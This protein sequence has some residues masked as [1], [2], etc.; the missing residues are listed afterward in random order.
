MAGAG[1]R[2]PARYGRGWRFPVS[3]DEQPEPEGQDELYAAFEALGG[4]LT[5]DE[6][7]RLLGSDQY[8]PALV[9]QARLLLD[10]DGAAAE[11]VVQA[12]FA[13]LQDAWSR[14]GDPGQQARVWLLRAT[15]N[16]SRSV[17]RHRDAGGR[18]A[19]QPAADAPGAADQA[20]GGPDLDAG[21]GALGAL[22]VRQRE[23]VVLHTRQGLSRR[24]AA[25]VM[26]ISVGAFSSHLARGTSSRRHPPQPK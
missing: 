23:A 16:R 4:P 3:H 11:Q 17:R 22:P 18:G 9:Q 15:V 12:S 1:G 25:Q 26:G 13:A 14:L 20:A 10:G 8:R 24:Q 7:T 5:W 19:S 21:A 6:L 2:G